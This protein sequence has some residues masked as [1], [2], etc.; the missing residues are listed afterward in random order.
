LGEIK[1]WDKAETTL[2]DIL[3]KSKHEF[4]IEEI[5]E[6]TNHEILSIRQSSWQIAEKTV[7]N[8]QSITESG[9]NRYGPAPSC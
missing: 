5:I 2:K 7:G 6:F 4:T 9:I 3:K 1:T 8:G